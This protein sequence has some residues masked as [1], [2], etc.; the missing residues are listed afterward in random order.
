MKNGGLSQSKGRTAVIFVY[1]RLTVQEAQIGKGCVNRPQNKNRS[2][3]FSE[4]RH[5][6]DRILYCHFPEYHPPP[7]RVIQ[8]SHEAD[9]FDFPKNFW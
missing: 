7:S 2:G 1:A 5:G 8:H 3:K 4:P 6:Q 9:N